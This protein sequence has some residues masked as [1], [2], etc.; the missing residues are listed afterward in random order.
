[1]GFRPG[2]SK[3]LST[4]RSGMEDGDILV[5]G[6]TPDTGATM[7]GEDE[8][9]FYRVKNRTRARPHTN[10]SQEDLWAHSEGSMSGL[11]RI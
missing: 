2:S 8:A 11:L 4:A 6:D 5:L 9:P 7:I 10:R 3:T 1:M